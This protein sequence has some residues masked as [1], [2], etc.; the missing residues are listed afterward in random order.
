VLHYEKALTLNPTEGE[1]Y[2]GLGNA[3]AR[4]GQVEAAI[5]YFREAVKLR[6]D[7]ADAYVA[8]ARSLAAQGNND[9]AERYYQEALR[10]LKSKN[11]GAPS[12]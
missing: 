12:P 8:L 10:L 7:F 4:R 1:I 6:P 9:E 5:A 11:K 3:L 2:F